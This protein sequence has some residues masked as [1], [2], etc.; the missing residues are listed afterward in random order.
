MSTVSLEVGPVQ[1]DFVSSIR[2]GSASVNAPLASLPGSLCVSVASPA[3]EVTVASA[4]DVYSRSVPGT[5]DPS[6]GI[7]P[8]DSDSVAGTVPDGVLSPPTEEASA[9]PL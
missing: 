5:N 4:V 2:S 9:Q 3:V 6:D 7:V 8:I 1:L